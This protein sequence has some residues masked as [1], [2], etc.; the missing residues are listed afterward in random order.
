MSDARSPEPDAPA[1]SLARHPDFLKLWAG[2]TVSTFGSLITRVALP[3]LA[4]LTLGA[5]PLQVALL[6]MA[7]GL[8]P[9]LAGPLA[10][11]WVDRLR[12]RPLLVAADIGRFLLLA[13]VPVAAWRGWL[14]LPL[15]YA[16]AF[17][18]SL[19]TVLF[20]VAYQ[21]YLPTLAPRDALVEGNSKLA[22]SASVAEFAGFG[23]SGILV[24]ALTAPFAILID[25]VTFA[26]S[27]TML[28]WIRKPEQAPPRH[29]GAVPDARRELRE[30]VRLV[31]RDRLLRPLALAAGADAF[32]THI[33]VAVLMLFLLRE[34]RL[35]PG[36][37]GIVFGVGGLASLGGALAARRLEARFGGGDAMVGGLLVYRLG[38][39]AVTFAGGP[40]GLVLLLLAGQQ[41]T[42]SAYTVFDITRIS[43]IQR[44]VP[45]RFLGRVSATFHTIE[46][47]AMLA[48]LLVGGLLGS[49]IGL[50]PTLLAGS[51][52]AL[53]SVAILALSPIRG[54]RDIPAGPTGGAEV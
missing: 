23:L 46:R 45:D 9:L 20:D 38:S 7:D 25:A 8:P 47:G 29:G 4:I 37:I 43:L 41:A 49:W 42:D 22:A 54:L 31:A 19:L 14:Q 1:P 11:V 13:S 39:F 44:L 50:R 12:R 15:L 32:F 27:A 34:L 24:Q 40:V 48:G 26:V 6:Q 35:E 2:Q 36:P 52:G 17:G 21:A 5:T 10:G 53:V 51:V 16:V 30:G 18:A 28:G 33:W 3:L